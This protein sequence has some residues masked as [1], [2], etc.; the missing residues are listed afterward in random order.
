M[1]NK[2]GNLHYKPIT[3]PFVLEQGMVQSK[4]GKHTHT[5]YTQKQNKTKPPQKQTKN[6][7]KMALP[8]TGRT[9]TWNQVEYSRRTFDR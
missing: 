3:S 9:P 1:F 4:N 5:P 7:P 8:F 2:V 6:T